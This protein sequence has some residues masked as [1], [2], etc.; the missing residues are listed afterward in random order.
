MWLKQSVF[1]FYKMPFVP[2]FRCPTR[3][4][5]KEYAMYLLTVL[6]HE[7]WVSARQFM[8]SSDFQLIIESNLQLP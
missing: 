5:N 3:K 6:Y 8:T 1:F 2:F 4:Q 7:S